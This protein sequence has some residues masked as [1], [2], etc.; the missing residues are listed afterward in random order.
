MNTKNQNIKRAGMFI[1]MALL[2]KG[3]FAQ[4]APAAEAAPAVAASTSVWANGNFLIMFL[5]TIIL[6]CVLFIL[7][8]IVKTLVEEDTAQVWKN[9]HAGKILVWPLLLL[10]SSAFAQSAT[11]PSPPSLTFGMD[12]TVFWVMM[13]ILTF[14]FIAVLVMCYVLYSFLVRKELIKPAASMLPKWLQF[15]AMMGND[16]PIEKDVEVLMTDHDYDGIQELDNGMPPFLKYIFILTI[17]FA[18]YYWIDYHVVEAS[19]LQLQE[20][21][22]QLAQG[23]AEKAEYIKKAGALVD[24]NTVKLM[25]DPGIIASGEKIYAT[26]CVACHGDKGQGGVGPNLTDA[27]WIHGG[28]IKSIFKTI[29]YGVPE[30]GMRSWQSDI[31]PGDMQALTSF[32]LKNLAG[33]NVA[34]KEPQGDLYNPSAA[35]D[36]TTPA[37]DSASQ[38]SAAPVDSVKK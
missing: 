31:K 35:T 1:S 18:V 25:E 33:K 5:T 7:A 37:K 30:K 17:L 29:K 28:D 19:P 15:N 21:E 9:R 14:L 6:L 3:I 22:N 32:L 11:P 23:E 12:S 20:Y 16:Q 8:K 24:E 38:T 4:D 13:G 34:G 36:A 27:Y 10:S 2:S 26:N